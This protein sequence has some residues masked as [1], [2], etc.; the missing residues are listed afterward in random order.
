MPTGTAIAR[1]DGEVLRFVASTGS[2]YTLV[3]DAAEGDSGPRPAE[4]LLVAQAGCTA[5]DVVSILRKKRQPFTSY[6]VRVTGD[7]RQ[8]PPPHVFESIRIVHVVEGRVD[9]EAVRRAIELSAT[10]HCTVSAN[11][12]SGVAQIHHAYLIRTPDGDERFRVVVVTGPGS[13][14]SMSEGRIPASGRST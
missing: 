14:H 11:L 8:D 10:K 13:T 12:A 2:G 3:M 4:L 5:M 1:L 9:P 6:E 7:Q